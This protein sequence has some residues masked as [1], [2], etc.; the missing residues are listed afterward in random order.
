MISV[1]CILYHMEC[2]RSTYKKTLSSPWW[3]DFY[4]NS[5]LFDI[6]QLL[7]IEI[8]GYRTHCFLY[9][10]IQ[11]YSFLYFFILTMFSRYKT[12]LIFLIL[13]VS[14]ALFFATIKFFLWNELSSTFKPD[15]Q[16]IAGYLS[17]GSAFAFLIWGAFAQIFLK[18]YFLFIIA[19]LSFLLVGIGYLVGYRTEW[20]FAFTVVSLWFLYGLWNVMKSVIIS[21]EIKKTWL[22]ETAVT[23][24]VGMMFVL[25]IITGSLL[26]SV[27]SENM[28]HSGYIILLVYLLLSALVSLFLNYDTITL[29][30]L[31]SRGWKSYFLSREQS[32]VS[33]MKQYIPDLLFISRKYGAIIVASSVLWSL[34]TIISQASVE[35]SAMAFSMK[36][37]EATI[38]LLYSAVGAIIGSFLSIRMNQK[39]WFYFLIFNV[40]FALVVF[41]IPLL[42]TSFFRVSVLATLLGICFG[43]AVN[44]SDS[45]LL[46]CYGDENK[47]EY[48]AST[49]WLIFSIILFCSMFLSSI[50]LKQFWYQA[51]MYVFSLIILVVSGW[52][53]WTESRKIW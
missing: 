51:V 1:G 23:A 7:Y 38:L 28:G 41:L 26:G 19:F 27:I 20:I 24:I 33:A 43:T 8:Y 14:W 42:G 29:S 45:Y 40:L 11:I 34:S 48:G 16:Q 53:Y 12:F 50:A 4:R 2:K 17:L 44:L 22:P 6:S 10:K 3:Y 35:Y 13:V 31:V 49:A 25:C 30:S 15:L 46:R 37:S 18:K 32:L 47:K 9:A 21:I 36:N 52:L 39:R 5:R